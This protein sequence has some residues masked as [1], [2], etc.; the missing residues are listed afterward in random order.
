MADSDSNVEQLLAV[1]VSRVE[2]GTAE[3]PAAIDLTEAIATAGLSPGEDLQETL[4]WTNRGWWSNQTA[5]EQ[6]KQ[7]SG[8]LRRWAE[9][10][11]STRGFFAYRAAAAREALA[12]SASLPD[13]AQALVEDE[14]I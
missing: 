1:V 2:D 10:W 12:Q 8:L 6:R 4:T 9:L 13:E 7:I 11:P 3:A 14:V 5:I